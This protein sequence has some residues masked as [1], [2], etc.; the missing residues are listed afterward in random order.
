MVPCRISRP[1]VRG[2][3]G[4]PRPWE[5]GEEEGDAWGALSSAAEERPSHQSGVRVRVLTERDRTRA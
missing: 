3:T 1:R 4:L 2:Q 5:E